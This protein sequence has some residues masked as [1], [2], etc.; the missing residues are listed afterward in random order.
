VLVAANDRAKAVLGWEPHRSSLEAMIA[1]AWDWRRRNPGG[2]A[3]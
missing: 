3:D 2:Y 1:S